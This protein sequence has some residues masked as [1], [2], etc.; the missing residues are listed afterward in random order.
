M[1]ISSRSSILSQKEANSLFSP[2][3]SSPLSSPLFPLLSSPLFPLLCSPLFPLLSSPHAPLALSPMRQGGGMT[4]RAG[5][6]GGLW[7]LGRGLATST[8]AGNR[9]DWR[10]WSAAG[11]PP[12]RRAVCY[13]QAERHEAY[14]D[15]LWTKYQWHRREGCCDVPTRCF[16]CTFSFHCHFALS[17]SCCSRPSLLLLFSP[18]GVVFATRSCRHGRPYS[19]TNG[20]GRLENL[21]GTVTAL[22]RMYSSLGHLSCLLSCKSSTC[23]T[24]S[25]KFDENA[26]GIRIVNQIVNT[27]TKSKACSFSVYRK[28]T[29]L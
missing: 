28:F 12:P 1:D 13:C 23:R 5:G 6:G 10:G 4:R 24:F 14:D 22:P 29:T 18:A 9:S 27:Y 8:A 25:T 2:L 16:V 7:G 17:L 15:V 26:D 3:L 20:A 11:Q 21:Q 19:T